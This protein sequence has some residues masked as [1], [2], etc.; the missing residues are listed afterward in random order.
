MLELVSRERFIAILLLRSSVLFAN[1]DEAA[2]H[3]LKLAFSSNY[4]LSCVG[5]KGYLHIKGLSNA[6]AA[7][8]GLTAAVAVHW[9]ILGIQRHLALW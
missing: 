5:N 7:K 2:S 8:K 4:V 9:L 3:F 6:K 1:R